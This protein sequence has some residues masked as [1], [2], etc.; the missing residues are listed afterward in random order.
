[1]QVE[2]EDLLPGLGAGRVAELH[3]VH[4]DRLLDGC[5]H[6]ARGDD[7]VPVLS[8]GDVPEVRAMQTR[9]DERVSRSGRLAV[10]KR[11]DVLIAKDDARRRHRLRCD[12]RRTQSRRRSRGRWTVAARDLRQCALEL[13][14]GR[15]P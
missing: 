15:E 4:A 10:E 5:G 8:V 12:R 6:S 3:R 1:M 9:Y 7:H 11:Y 13:E 14:V 2:V